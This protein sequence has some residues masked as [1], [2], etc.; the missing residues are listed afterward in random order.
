MKSYAK[1]FSASEIGSRDDVANMVQ[2]MAQTERF[3]EVEG[4]FKAELATFALQLS[5]HVKLNASSLHPSLVVLYQDLTAKKLQYEGGACLI[6]L[7]REARV[8]AVTLIFA[9]TQPLDMILEIEEPNYDYIF[10]PDGR[11]ISEYGS[12]GWQNI[13]KDV[14]YSLYPFARNVSEFKKIIQPYIHELATS[15]GFKKKKMPFMQNTGYIRECEDV[16]QYIALSF[17]QIRDDFFVFLRVY[18]CIDQVEKIA[19]PYG[20]LS[21]YDMTFSFTIDS[22]SFAFRDVVANWGIASLQDVEPALV[23]I[24]QFVFEGIYEK[25]K[26]I[27]EIDALVNGDFNS[28]FYKN[29]YKIGYNLPSSLILTQLVGNPQFESLVAHAETREVWGG[30]QS[31]RE[32]GWSNLLKHLREEVKPIV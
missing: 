3:D 8:E 23:K 27:K 12:V 18:L 2:N 17:E 32:K 11:I 28:L 21:Q 14:D 15:Y 26:T 31:A 1:L 22:N 20:F 5:E 4:D 30:K 7:P 19:E 29:I 9:L 24:K 13:I 16:I 25:S 10:Y 6:E